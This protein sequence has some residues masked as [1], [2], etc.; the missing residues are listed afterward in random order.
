MTDDE[1]WKKADVNRILATHAFYYVQRTIEL[2]NERRIRNLKRPLT[3]E[4]L[5][6][7][8]DLRDAAHAVMPLADPISDKEEWEL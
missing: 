3:D 4:D 7:I 8:I 5:Q 2:V 6:K 1:L